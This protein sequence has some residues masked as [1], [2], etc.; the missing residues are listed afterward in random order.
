MKHP[1]HLTFTLL[2]SLCTLGFLPAAAQDQDEKPSNPQDTTELR[3]NTD[4]VKLIQFDFTPDLSKMNQPK[5]APLDK[6]WMEFKADLSLPRSLIDTTR[7]RKPTGY[8][9]LAPYSIW[10]K[11]GE[12]PVYDRTVEGR[13]KEQKIYW[14]FN[15]YRS[16]YN[17]DWSP[18]PS[19]GSM[20]Q[21]NTSPV[22]PAIC[23]NNLDFIMTLY[24]TFNKH[25]RTLRHNRKYANAWKTYKDYKPTRED[26]L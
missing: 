7:V 24:E 25:G 8:I 13:P 16:Y 6:K 11:Y 12:E 5:E 23:I 20:Y 2:L 14:T 3:L 17:D 9:R 19:T 22:G 21:M 15:P 26:S 1:D 10:T 4:A 18:T